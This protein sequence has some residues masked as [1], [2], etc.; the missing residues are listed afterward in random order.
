ME[1]SEEH[2]RRTARKSSKNERSD[3]EINL[4]DERYSGLGNVLSLG[5]GGNQCN[6]SQ[7]FDTLKR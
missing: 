5:A 4:G 6:S 2:T 3:E 7:E 1:S